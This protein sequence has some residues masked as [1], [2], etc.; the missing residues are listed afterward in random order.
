MTSD[1]NLARRKVRGG[2]VREGEY[3]VVHVVRG[4]HAGATAY[5]DDD[6]GYGV[7][8]VY[9]GV[10]YTSEPA[11]IPRSSL[12]HTTAT[13]LPLEKWKRENPDLARQIGVP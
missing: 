2:R 11:T 13:H 5:Y 10:P 3:G 8:V 4:R 12:R 1:F 9:F 6:E 7:A